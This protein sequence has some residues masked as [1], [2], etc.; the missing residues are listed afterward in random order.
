MK[1]T[2]VTSTLG[3]NKLERLDDSQAQLLA[4]L[5]AVDSNVLNV[6]N[7]AILVYKLSFHENGTD[8]DNLVFGILGNSDSM[9]FFMLSAHVPSCS[10]YVS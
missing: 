3:T 10:L 5:V 9:V 1:L 6:S 7:K 2:F 4:L 8:G